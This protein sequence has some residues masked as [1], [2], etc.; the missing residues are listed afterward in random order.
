M[1][2]TVA[3]PDRFP[4]AGYVMLD[5]AGNAGA[6]HISGAGV[7]PED[8]FTGYYPFGTGNSQ[9]TGRI[10][11]RGDYGA[12]V[13]DEHGNV[14]LAS[15]YI[16]QTCSLAQFES[17]TTCGGTRTILANRA[18]YVTEVTPYAWLSLRKCRRTVGREA[19]KVRFPR[20]GPAF[21]RGR[22]IAR[23]PAIGPPGSPVTQE[24]VLRC[25]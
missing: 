23:R 11:R 10:A 25:T 20:G 12:A 14:W 6:V 4:S 13:A 3:R 17:D 7:G 8:G 2:F 16:N 24:S 15:E 18:T 22:L 1:T 21:R 19:Q 5:S 9:Y